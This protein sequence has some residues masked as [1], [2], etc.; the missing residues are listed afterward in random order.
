MQSE[1]DDEQ[2][3]TEIWD[4]IYKSGPQ[5]IAILAEVKQL[6]EQVILS[7]VQHDW[8]DLDDQIVSI[9]TEG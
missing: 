9:A 6:D 2:I 7:V 5:S 4:E 3:R 1:I 8:F